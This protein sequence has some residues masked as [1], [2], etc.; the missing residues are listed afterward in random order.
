[1]WFE[2][3][4]A[5]SP[6]LTSLAKTGLWFA[7][8]LPALSVL[9]SWYQGAILHGRQTRGITESVLIYLL[10]STVILGLGV[11]WG[12]A[13]GLYIGLAALTLSTLTQTGWLWLRSLGILE[14]VKT[15]DAWP[16]RDLLPVSLN[17]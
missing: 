4:S 11:A 8:P 9:Q 16:K 14:Q 15:R 5:L 3:V 6:Q 2:T 17:Q 7:L 10:T 12:V 13:T 1:M